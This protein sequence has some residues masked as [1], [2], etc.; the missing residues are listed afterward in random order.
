MFYIPHS[1]TYEDDDYVHGYNMDNLRKKFDK[2]IK[3]KKYY[4][5]NFEIINKLVYK[6]K[7]KE[8]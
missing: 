4:L 2:E 3:N 7:K 6:N 8:N 5:N 1:N